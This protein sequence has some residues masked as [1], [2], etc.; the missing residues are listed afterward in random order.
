MIGG[1]RYA[2]ID[3]W[4]LHLH[5]HPERRRIQRFYCEICSGSFEAKSA[6]D[7]HYVTVHYGDYDGDYVPPPTV[8]RIPIDNLEPREREIDWFLTP[9]GTP[10]SGM[11][12]S[13]AVMV[14][15]VAMTPECCDTLTDYEFDMFDDGIPPEPYD[16]TLLPH[17]I[18][19][20]SPASPDQNLDNEVGSDEDTIS[21]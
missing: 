10:H 12:S 6:Y 18:F 13:V 15:T 14:G 19:N 2:G 11:P 17:V 21:F 7:F 8:R 1:L 20:E 5:L 4:E 9:M 16:P 3:S